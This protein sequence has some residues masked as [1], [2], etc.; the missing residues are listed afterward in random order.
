MDQ[1]EEDRFQHITWEP[2]GTDDS[3]DPWSPDENLLAEDYTLLWLI[4]RSPREQ[5]GAVLYIQPNDVV[6][7]GQDVD[8]RWDDPRMSRRHARFTLEPDEGAPEGARQVYFIWPLEA[9]NGITVNNEV[10]RGAVRL[11]END[12]LTMG[13]TV[14]VVKTLD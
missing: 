13:S 6:G 3:T 9:L 10:I 7:R 8:V 5:R 4:V 14:F 11:Q 2:E 12:E 1:P